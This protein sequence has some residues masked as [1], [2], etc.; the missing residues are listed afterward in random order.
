MADEVFLSI[1]NG[2]ELREQVGG[3]IDDDVWSQQV[4]AFNTMISLVGTLAVT[5]RQ[6]CV[7]AL[8]HMLHVGPLREHYL[9]LVD[10]APGKKRSWF[11]GVAAWDCIY[12]TDFDVDA[13]S[14]WLHSP[15]R[16]D[17]GYRVQRIPQKFIPNLEK[18]KDDLTASPESMNNCLNSLPETMIV[19]IQDRYGLLLQ[20]NEV[21]TG[22]SQLVPIVVAAHQSKQDT[23]IFEQPE[24]HLHPKS[25]LVIADLLITR[26][27]ARLKYQQFIIETHSEHIALRLLRRIRETSSGDHAN[28]QLSITPDRIAIIYAH[29]TATGTSVQELR[30]DETGEF[31]DRW[32]AG[33]FDERA[34]ELF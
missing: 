2:P 13:I 1:I 23:I 31:I 19:T 29:P 20:T 28:S 27:N 7:D 15:G 30:V 24:L 32:P 21:G 12:E 11:A 16:F 25:Q 9:P 3:S 8:K 34:E 26:A 14:E 33:F 5:I 6:N 4:A 22:I 18:L 10:P 17:T